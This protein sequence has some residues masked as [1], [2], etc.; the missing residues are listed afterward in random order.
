MNKRILQTALI[1]TAL[2]SVKPALTYAY[3]VAGRGVTPYYT[4]DGT[5]YTYDSQPGSSSGAYGIEASSM[6][7][8]EIENAKG[9]W[10]WIDPDCDGVAERY[11]MIR[12]NAYLTNGMTPDGKTV[13]SMGQWTVDGMVMHRMAYDQN[14]VAAAIQRAAMTHGDSFDGIY[15]GLI[16]TTEIRNAG[17][18]AT[19][20]GTKDVTKTVTVQKYLT[21]T[22]IQKS[23][24]ELSVTI[25]DD[26]GATTSDYEYEGLNTFHSGV[27]MWKPQK[28]KNSD[29]LLFYG[30]NSIVY[31]DYD[32]ILAGQLMKIG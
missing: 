32:G 21:V 17:K 7:L 15:S 2:V 3:T 30:Y 26:E 24:T 6:T 10:A 23:V 19:K 13:N 29:Y 14:A 9:S 11:Y 18:V 5:A 28:G 8:Q 12:S 1:I 25:S 16:T 20:T 4:S 27:T 22:V 31:Y